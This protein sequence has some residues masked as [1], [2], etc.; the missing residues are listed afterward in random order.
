MIFRRPIWAVIIAVLISLTLSCAGNNASPSASKGSGVSVD[1]QAARQQGKA[2][3]SGSAAAPARPTP[4]V[5]TV[6]PKSVVQSKPA[7]PSA[8][9]PRLQAK[10]DSADYGDV[11]VGDVVDQLF[12]FSNVGEQPLIVQR[13]EIKTVEGC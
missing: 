4:V 5:M 13:V 3:A 1:A 7:A 11:V 8:G 2:P 12:E 6:Q 10:I 9:G